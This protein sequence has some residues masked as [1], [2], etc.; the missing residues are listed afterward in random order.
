MT[1]ESSQA[2]GR[3]PYGNTLGTP[4]MICTYKKPARD[5]ETHDLY[6]IGK[7]LCGARVVMQLVELEAHTHVFTPTTNVWIRFQALRSVVPSEV[8]T[9]L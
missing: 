7:P 6:P 9:G 3:T 5:Q 1:S 2:K 8:L 4:N